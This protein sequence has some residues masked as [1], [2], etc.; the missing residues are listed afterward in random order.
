[1][2]HSN[3]NDWG[4]IDFGAWKDIDEELLG[5]KAEAPSLTTRVRLKGY[6]LEFDN[7]PPIVVELVTW[8]DWMHWV[9][10]GNAQQIAL[11]LRESM[12]LW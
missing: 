8:A 11:M 12:H 5:N 6:M 9:F 7:T 10:P 1:M 3:D 4:K 2:N